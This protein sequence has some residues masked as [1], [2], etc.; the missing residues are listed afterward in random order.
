MAKYVIT[1]AKE[2]YIKYTSHLDVMRMFKRAFKKSRLHLAHSQG[3]HPTPKLSIAQPLSLGY[4][5]RGEMAEFET[6]ENYD[7]QEVL[8]GLNEQMPTG[9]RIL[10]C[11]I[12]K[13]G[14]KGLAASC[15]A[16][17]YTIQIPYDGDED[18][19]REDVAE[20]FLSQDTI[21]AWKKTKKKK[22]PTEINIRPMIQSLRMERVGDNIIMFTKLDAGSKS[23]LSP[24]LLLHAFFNFT[25]MPV[26][27][28]K[29]EITR[30]KLYM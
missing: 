21:S 20:A 3:F 10:A 22:E 30:E 9:I 23:N 15:K 6:K 4:E 7:P 8:C 18:I 5:A 2:G 19:P 12:K 28:E 27:R 14:E 16:A 25:G 11:R 24:E 17:D 1:F 13:K 26:D 29:I